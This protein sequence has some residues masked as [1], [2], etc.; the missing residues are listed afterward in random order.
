M[1]HQEIARRYNKRVSLSWYQRKPFPCQPFSYGVERMTDHTYKEV[2]ISR[3]TEHFII[4]QYT[5]AGLGEIVVNGRKYLL[6]PGK[7]FLVSTPS[8]CIY[9]QSPDDDL[10]QFIY[11]GISG[12]AA[13]EV[14]QE[15][16]EKSGPVLTISPD[17]Q[18]L[19]MLCERFGKIA[20]HG[21][22]DIYENS[23]FGYNFLLTLL[24]EQEPTLPHAKDKMPV[25]L[26]KALTFIEQNL[27]NTLLDINMLAGHVQL[28][29]FYFTRLFTEYLGCSPRKYLQAQRLFRSSQLLARDCSLPLKSVIEQCGFASETY[30]CRA[31]QKAYHISPGKYRSLYKFRGLEKGSDWEWLKKRYRE[32]HPKEE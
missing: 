17:S 9:M 15:I 12:D 13:R 25:S 21:I 3:D 8:P 11:V 24:R 16:M 14:A 20:E 26:E 2:L 7:A 18:T 22:Q 30:F 4:F 23:V 28:S 31:F 19:E 29:V 5:F 32:T 1:T 10:Y 6:P 27:A